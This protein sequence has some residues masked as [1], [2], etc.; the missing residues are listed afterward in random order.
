MIQE[1]EN[2]NLSKRLEERVKELTCLYELSKVVQ[3]LELGLDKQIEKI[4]EI[5]PKGWQF[6][7][8]LKVNI[9]YHNSNF[10][11]ELNQVGLKESIHI[12][13]REIGEIKVGYSNLTDEKNSFLKE[14]QQLLSQIAIELGNL[15]ARNE[16]I[17]KEKLLNE[18][19]QREDRLHILAELTAGV[20]HELNT[21]LGNILGYAEILKK[22]IEDKNKRNDAQKIITSAL[23]AREIVKKLMYFSCEMPS[24]FKPIDINTVVK[25]TCDL[26]SLQLKQ[27]NKHVEQ[28]I[29]LKPLIV[30][31]D[32]MQLSQV[33]INLILNAKDAIAANEMIFIST[34]DLNEFAQVIIKDKG[35]GISESDL[36]DIFKPFFTTKQHGTGLGLSVA[37][38]IIQSHKGKIEVKS[39]KNK[40][41]EFIITLPKNAS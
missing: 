10:G 26:L 14:E 11:L 36:E 13:Q 1:D 8:R 7:E 19:M 5:I 4:I 37:H 17:E 16:Q 2:I 20:A 3:Q 30:N 29:E 35:H 21:P 39:E 40:G 34:K 15:I 27:S 22:S 41:T 24:N 23:S 18:Q 12:N 33:F 32:S 9:T 31:G 28:N 6:P 25:D 38:G